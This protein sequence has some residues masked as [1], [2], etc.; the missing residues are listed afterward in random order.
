MR[1]VLRKVSPRPEDSIAH[2]CYANSALIGVP[3]LTHAKMNG[4]VQRVE[5]GEVKASPDIVKGF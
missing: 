1:V 5:R 2:R 3:A 4:A